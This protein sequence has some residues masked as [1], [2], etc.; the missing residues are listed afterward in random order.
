MN[1]VFKGLS[2]IK[3]VCFPFQHSAL[4][5][6]NLHYQVN[7]CLLQGFVTTESRACSALGVL[8]TEVQSKVK[9]LF[10]D[11]QY[12]PICADSSKIH[13]KMNTDIMELISR[14]IDGGT[15]RT[16]SP[17]AFLRIIIADFN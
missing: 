9:E 1:I 3:G 7:K 4:R 8:L 17:S 6:H 16:F 5:L 15:W 12:V 11:V 13:V 10:A 2:Q 14:R